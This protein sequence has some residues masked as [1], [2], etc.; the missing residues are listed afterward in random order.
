LE[1]NQRQYLFMQDYFYPEVP[2]DTF[3]MVD[4]VVFAG[5]GIQENVYDD[6]AGLDTKGRVV[7]LLDGEPRNKKG[8]SRISKTR[9]TSSWTIELQKKIQR[10]I[11]KEATM[12]LV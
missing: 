8:I 10:A 4:T 1:V 5:Y 2:R 9:I 7:L 12:V 6:Y 3:I 11:E